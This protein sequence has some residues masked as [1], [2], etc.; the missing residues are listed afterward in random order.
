ML[1]RDFLLFAF[2]H[3]DL[4]IKLQRIIQNNGKE[5]KLCI[6]INKLSEMPDTLRENEGGDAKR[7]D[8]VLEKSKLS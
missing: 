7:G 8:Q 1:I 4:E 6:C 3:A 2:L 5:F